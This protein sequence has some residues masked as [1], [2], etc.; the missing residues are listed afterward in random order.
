MKI[1]PNRS[2][3]HY[4]TFF[5]EESEFEFKNARKPQTL[6]TTSNSLQTDTSYTVRRTFIGNLSS[7]SI[8]LSAGSGETFLS[9]ADVDYVLSLETAPGT[10]AVGDLVQLTSSELSGTGSG[11]LTISLGAGFG[12]SKRRFLRFP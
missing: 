3:R 7:G 5:R 1:T 11:T 8:S 2:G 12:A 4:P 9:A 6:L 10:G